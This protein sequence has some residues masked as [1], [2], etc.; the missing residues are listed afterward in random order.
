MIINGTNLRAISAGFLSIFAAQLLATSG[1][2]SKVATEVNANTKTVNYAWLGSF[3]RMREWIGDRV[4]KDLTAYTYQ[5]TGKK[6]E[7]TVEVDAD[8][9]RYDNLGIVKPQIQTMAFEA[10]GHYD[11][12][13]FGLLETNG[14]CYDGKA[15]FAVDHDVGGVSFSNL[16]N[17]K[18]TRESLLEYRAE[19]RGIT[20]DTGKPL[21]IKP[22]LLVIPP[23][24]EQTAIDILNKDTLANGES[25]TTKGLMD[26]IV[27]D[28]LTDADAWY[29]MDCSRPL[30]PIILQKNKEIQFVAMDKEDDENVFMRDTFRYGVDSR[31]NVGYGLWQL[32]YKSTGTV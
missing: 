4:L 8:D 14:N 16:G 11:E 15:F 30:K 19:M 10:K 9:I 13:V 18:L 21:R 27:A 26:Y 31:C 28:W 22:T 7:A 17:K 5:I 1:D 20:T 2:Y 3:P 23:E 32:A 25:N 24:L 12:L 6:F 29:I